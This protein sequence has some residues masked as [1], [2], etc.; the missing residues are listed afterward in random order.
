MIFDVAGLARIQVVQQ[1]PQLD[2]QGCSIPEP[3]L[4]NAPLIRHSQ[5]KSHVASFSVLNHTANV[6]SH[7][8]VRC[9]VDLQGTNLTA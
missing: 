5:G 6:G 9:T 3:F 2:D 1:K 4:P 8:A 7:Y